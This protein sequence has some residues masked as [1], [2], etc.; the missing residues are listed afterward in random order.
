MRRSLFSLLTLSC[1]MERS[2]STWPER[3]STWFC[4][5]SIVPVRLGQENKKEECM[6]SINQSLGELGRRIPPHLSIFCCEVLLSVT[7]VW[8]VRSSSLAV[9]SSCSYTLACCSFM[10]RRTSS[11]FDKY[12]TEL[13]KDFLKSL[14]KNSGIMFGITVGEKII[15]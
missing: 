13:K 14:K 2:C 5:D 8:L 7:S 6:F 12:C 1:S 11:C 4:R 9:P 10:S 3:V 15:L